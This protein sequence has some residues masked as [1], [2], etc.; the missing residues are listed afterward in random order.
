MSAS[1]QSVT[2]LAILLPESFRGGCS[3][4]VGRT[5]LSRKGTL[6]WDCSFPKVRN[7]VTIAKSRPLSQHI[8][9]E[10]G[11]NAMLYHDNASR[12]CHDLLSLPMLFLRTRLQ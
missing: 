10:P 4:G 11:M 1:L 2:T 6:I 7:I 9:G 5:D 8:F 12:R 3:F